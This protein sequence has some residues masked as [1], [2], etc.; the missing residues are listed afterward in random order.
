[1][2]NENDLLPFES[3]VPESSSLPPSSD[4]E[5]VAARINGL[6]SK[7]DELLRR[8]A[9]LPTATTAPPSLTVPASL[10]SA[11]PA[12]LTPN[13]ASAPPAPA[14]RPYTALRLALFS[15]LENPTRFLNDL[16]RHYR[17]NKAFFYSPDD[18]RRIDDARDAMT[19]HAADWCDSLTNTRPG[20]LLSWSSFITEF[21]HIY[22][23]GRELDNKFDSLLSLKM[24][25][26]IVAFIAE[27]NSQLAQCETVPVGCAVAFFRRALPPSLAEE[28]NMTRINR[29][30]G[31]CEWPDLGEMQS[32]AAGLA[33]SRSFH[34]RPPTAVRT[35][36]PGP[37]TPPLDVPSPPASSY[38]SV[39]LARSPPVPTTVAAVVVPAN[40]DLRRAFADEREKKG[41]CRYCGSGE[42]TVAKCPKVAE[43]EEKKRLGKA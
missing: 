30:G 9:P 11:W 17:A 3:S 31:T 15:G 28:L 41:L 14:S 19:G 32:A 23:S 35:A 43:K 16:D 25:G 12:L 7:F 2:S 18:P 5:V 26:P 6:E 1:M 42:H 4:P 36:V 13:T 21:K 34:V 8:L 40:I 22:L 37:T 29:F 27:F 20:I 33:G 39:A 24:N 10:A 38:A